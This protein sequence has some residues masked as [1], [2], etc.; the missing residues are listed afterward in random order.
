MDLALPRDTASFRA[1]YACILPLIKHMSLTAKSRCRESHTRP[2]PKSNT[3]IP[4]DVSKCQCGVAS[5]AQPLDGRSPGYRKV[6]LA[7][8]P[9]ISIVDDDEPLR[10]ATKGFI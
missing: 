9:L 3:T 2:G 10:Q 5:S 8:K 4:L 6:D 1:A 7:S